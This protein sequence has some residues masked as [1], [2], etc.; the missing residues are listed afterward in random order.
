MYSK[1]VLSSKIILVA[2]SALLAYLGILKFKQYRSQLQIAQQVQ[3][4]Q[5]QA[6]D[7]KT[8]NDKLGQELQSVNSTD[9]KEQVVR[10]QLGY[11]KQGEVVY[12]FSDAPVAES[13]PQSKTTE[14]SNFSK[15]W[16]Y[17]FP[18]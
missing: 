11:K 3:S 13:Q 8:Q 4:L 18:K 17:F 7:L 9:Y 15:W 1:K 2:L 14:T 5:Q 12:K 6:N 10:E 16:S